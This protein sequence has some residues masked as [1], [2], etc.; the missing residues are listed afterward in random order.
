MALDFFG[1]YIAARIKTFNP[2]GGQTE[3]ELWNPATA[4]R[5][6]PQL[7]ALNN[8]SYVSEVQVEVMMARNSRVSLTMTPPYDDGL[9]IINS[10]LIQWGVGSLQLQVGYTTG[11]GSVG[12]MRSFVYG[13]LL[14][15]PDVSIGSD[16]TI[17]LN[18]LGV[19]Y[20][21]STAN[22]ANGRH[23]EPGTT[24]AEAIEAVLK[25]YTN[26]DISGIWADFGLA[27]NQS[28]KGA[29]VD[30][31]LFK[32]VL[33]E[34][35]Q[36][37]N[38]FDVQQVLSIE[39]GPR[40]DWW[41]VKETCEKYGLDIF[42]IGESVQVRDRNAWLIKQPN[43]GVKRFVLRGGMDPSQLLF[44]ALSLS[45]PTAAVWISSGVGEVLQ[46]DVKADKSGITTTGQVNKDNTKVSQTK[47]GTYDQTQD[48][49]GRT[50][51]AGLNFPGNPDTSALAYA[52]GEFKNKNFKKGIQIEVDTIGI[53][54]LIPG[55]VITIEGTSS[56]SSQGPGIF[57]GVYGVEKV[58][59]NIGIGGYT[60]HFS[61][62][63]NF[64]P[65][66]FAG[67]AAAE[68]D[69]ADISSDPQTGL[70]FGG[71]AA[72]KVTVKGIADGQT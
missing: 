3:F 6:P 32:P 46:Q 53:P 59:H 72:H 1:C 30:H 31:D 28:A 34:K 2:I 60:T 5:L 45:S 38:S 48:V 23:F 26:F 65:R 63:S 56:K 33:G 13:G 25:D 24:P 14:Q 66:V 20:A 9:E 19:G 67:A 8:L 52:R 68:G 16:I 49:H 43:N 44:P 35:V 4:G 41:F 10:P 18:A 15:K 7:A 36:D 70:Q 11:D 27:K 55:E 37:K 29:S 21:L 69:V 62:L 61:A 39:V 57:D 64:M 12:A 40:N 51:D 17:T 42:I 71:S 47:H 58:I 50:Q 54:D 22:N